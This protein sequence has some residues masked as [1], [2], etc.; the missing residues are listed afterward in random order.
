[1]SLATSP[2]GQQEAASEA[3]G[4]EVSDALREVESGKDEAR[5]FRHKSCPK[6]T[7]SNEMQK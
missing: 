2:S 4:I 7:C 3:S 6:Q 1:M 5:D